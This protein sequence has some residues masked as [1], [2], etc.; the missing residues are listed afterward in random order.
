MF[1]NYFNSLNALVLGALLIIS[2]CAKIDDL[3]KSSGDPGPTLISDGSKISDSFNWSTT[4]NIDLRV[5]VDDKYNGKYYYKVEVYDREPTDEDANLLAAGLAK[6]TQDLVSKLTIPTGLE[7]VYIKTTTPTKQSSYTMQSVKEGKSFDLKFGSTSGL[8]ASADVY[9]L[10]RTYSGASAKLASVSAPTPPAAPAVPANAVELKD[11]VNYDWNTIGNNVS[12][13]IPE[14]KTYAGDFQLNIY[15][16]NAITVYVLGKWVNSNHALNIGSVNKLVVLSTGEVELKSITQD[17]SG[18]NTNYG[19]VKVK[20]VTQSNNTSNLYNYGRFEIEDKLTIASSGSFTSTNYVEAKYITINSS[21]K[22]YN[23]G[24]I[25]VEE[26]FLVQS[27]ADVINWGTVT[28]NKLTTNTSSTIT[29]DGTLKITT[30]DLNSSTFNVNCFTTVTNLNLNGTTINIKEKSRLNVGSIHGFDDSKGSNGAKFNLNG[31]SIL[32]V[33]VKATFSSHNVIKNVS[34]TEALVMMK[35]ISH[36]QEGRTID[37]VGS[38]EVATDKLLE[39]SDDDIHHTFTAG[40]KLVAGYKKATLTIPSDGC[41]NGGYIP[42]PEPQ[43]EDNTITPVPLGIHSYAF[44]DNWPSTEKHDYDMNDLV[45]DVKITKHQDKDN[46]VTKVVLENTIRSV[47]ASKILAAGIQLDNVDASNI[48]KATYSMPNLT[49]TV[50]KLNGVGVE[51]QQNKAVVA[52][53]D[54][55]HE[56]F[57]VNV[58]ATTRPFISTG[59]GGSHDPIVQTITIEFNTPLEQFIPD[60]LNPFIAIF[61]NSKGGRYEVHLPGKPA[62]N[63][64][65]TGLL[66]I[67]QGIG[68]GLSD[69]DPFKSKHNEPFAI[70]VPVSFVYPYESQNIKSLYP[71]FIEWVNSSGDLHQDWYNYPNR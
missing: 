37:F 33:S 66:N 25:D 70:K 28:I 60:D 16:P 63:L 36:K 29:N 10:K 38:M 22:F 50:L 54:H 5:A 53:V 71:K 18:V 56:A 48:K 68:G 42:Q 39:N 67:E 26:E 14:G 2:S 51:G 12:Y 11:G 69:K 15:K 3:Y 6:K 9:N 65:N 27:T 49:N 44:E 46:R 40:A 34:S 52:I 24:I 31:G 61:P 1:K 43:P 30:A 21:S 58:N 57:G 20:N 23:T 64:I 55:A 4:K 19:I 8:L 32:D 35:E 7:Y 62:T 17:N 47:G 45:V 13:Y 41:N 59:P